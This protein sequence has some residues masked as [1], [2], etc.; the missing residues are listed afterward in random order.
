MI[1]MIPI[2]C[3]FLC[4]L[5]S[6]PTSYRNNTGNSMETAPINSPVGSKWLVLVPKQLPIWE[7][8]LL[9][10]RIVKCDVVPPCSL[11]HVSLS[12]TYAPEFKKEGLWLSPCSKCYVTSIFVSS[13]QVKPSF[14]YLLYKS[15]EYGRKNNLHCTND[16]I[17]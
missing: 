2:I 3:S 7:H 17:N 5:C 15:D 1:L 16:L 4:M 10:S 8:H 9:A 11:D 13:I 12:W 6:I 14:I